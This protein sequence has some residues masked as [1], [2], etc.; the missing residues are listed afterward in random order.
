M[1]F[2]DGDTIVADKKEIKHF[3]KK[4][5]LNYYSLYI[6][7]NYYPYQIYITIMFLFL[8]KRNILHC[9]AH[10]SKI[11]QNSDL[12]FRGERIFLHR[13][14]KVVSRKESGGNA[15]EGARIAIARW[16]SLVFGFSSRCPRVL[17]LLALVV[18]S[19]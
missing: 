17:A 18:A 13:I 15:R 7:S 8:N 14:H 10:D 16:I 2:N 9:F 6:Y 4:I 5:S 12:F 11:N 3:I 1:K 19:R